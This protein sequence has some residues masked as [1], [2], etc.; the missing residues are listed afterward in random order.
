ML[1]VVT[2]AAAA[3][4]LAGSPSGTASAPV[5]VQAVAT[6]RIVS[7]VRLKLDAVA[8]EGAPKARDS[9]VKLKDGTEQPARLI[10][11]Q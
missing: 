1:W 7:G 9:I 10:E 11:F 5:V 6:V 3:S 2:A 4:G 8:N